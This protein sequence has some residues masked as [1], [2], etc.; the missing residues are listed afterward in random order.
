MGEIEE[1]NRNFSL[2]RGILPTEPSVKT[3]ADQTN[4][5]KVFE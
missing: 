3:F 2:V 1:K 4:N 5:L